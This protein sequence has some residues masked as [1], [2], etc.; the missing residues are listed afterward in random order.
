MVSKNAALAKETELRTNEPSVIT[1]RELAAY[2]R[3]HPSTV[4]RL[5]REEKIPS[6][7]VG[8]D[9]RFHREAI[10]KWMRQQHSAN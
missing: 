6:F 3:V 10:D 1:L 4:Y 7:R 9:W 8:S 2:L 5:L